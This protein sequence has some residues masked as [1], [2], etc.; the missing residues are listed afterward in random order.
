[1]RLNS[2]IKVYLKVFTLTACTLLVKSLPVTS[3]NSYYLNELA[4]VVN[5]EANV[6]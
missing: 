2:F 3:D 6:S 1:M 5:F 4:S